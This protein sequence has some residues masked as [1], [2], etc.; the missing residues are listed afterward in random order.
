MRTK[1]REPT[2]DESAYQILLEKFTEE[3]FNYIHGRN[4]HMNR[5]WKHMKK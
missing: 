3:N 1:E 4:Q 2:A 5:P